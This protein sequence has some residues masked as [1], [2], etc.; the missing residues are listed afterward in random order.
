VIRHVM[1]ALLALAAGSD[2]PGAQSCEGP[3]VDPWVDGLRDRV[4]ST[5]P[6]VHY[7]IELFGP[8]LTCEG[9]V[10]TEFDGVKLGAVRLGFADSVTFRIETMPPETSIV[11]LRTSSGF[12]DEDSARKAIEAYSADIGLDI[13]WAKPTST[14]EGEERVQ[15]FWDPDTGLNA[16]ASLFFKED[17][18][19][20]LRFSMAL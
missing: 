9:S 20:A 1:V 19:V 17:T 10:T 7:A 8:P 6:M 18:L 11:T 12:D 15:T 14:V 2:A 5:N 13:D 16:S 3:G 4:L